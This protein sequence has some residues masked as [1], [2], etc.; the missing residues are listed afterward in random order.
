MERTYD[1]IMFWVFAVAAAAGLAVLL[2]LWFFQPAYGADDKPEWEAPY[3]DE[4]CA[5]DFACQGD[6]I[7]ELVYAGVVVPL[8]A[9]DMT[10]EECEQAKE[11]IIAVT[12]A[13]SELRC[14]PRL[15]ARQNL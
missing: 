13:M 12:G 10:K 3:V 7:F 1:R 11:D 6:P 4:A 15:V 9:G 8:A 14:R 2:P 5:E